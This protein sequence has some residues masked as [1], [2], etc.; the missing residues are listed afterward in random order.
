MDTKSKKSNKF[1]Y[2][3]MF[4]LC[5]ISFIA[6]AL[7]IV[8]NGFLLHNNAMLGDNLEMLY[9]PNSSYGDHAANIWADNAVALTALRNQMSANFAFSIVCAVITLGAFVYLCMAVGDRNENGKII[10]KA[11]DRVYTEIQLLI[12]VA[13]LTVGGWLFLQFS[14]LAIR[15]TSDGLIRNRA[16]MINFYEP[17]VIAVGIACAAGAVAAACGLWIFLSC[18]RKIKAGYFL[19]Q[20]II[21]KICIVLYTSLFV[22]GSLTRKAVLIA[23]LLCLL[24]A[25]IICAPFILILI[26]I[27]APKMARKF[28]EIKYGVDEVKNGNLGHKIP[29]TGNG[30]FDKLAQGINEI[31]QSS[32]AAVQNEMKNQ[33]M[34]AELISNVSHDLKTPLTSMVTYID[35]LKSEGLASEHAEEYLNIL[36][37]KTSRL[38]QLTEDLFEAAKASSGAMPVTMEKVDLLSLINQGLG[39][40][41][42]RI[43]DSGLEMIIKAELDKYYVWADGQLLWRVIENLLNNVLKYAQENTR[44]YINVSATAAAD[45]PGMVVLDMKNI[46]RQALNIEAGELMERFKRG[47]ESRATEGSG[48]GLAIAKDLVKLQNGWLDVKIDGDL[49]KATVMLEKA[50]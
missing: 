17:A 18:V 27:F 16:L 47:D 6:A 35:L 30:E 36:D 7:G 15:N 22:G 45:N 42:Q 14:V 11:V 37:Q 5:I 34:K 50:E 33:R 48:L 25:T 31:S 38:R 29:L 28:E 23:A 26:F 49:F 19:K 39:E 21:G 40:M 10:L 20:S 9:F 32:N 8:Q 3:T 13:M 1:I 46:S 4:L 44:V 24:S 41:N 2:K 43:A 12:I